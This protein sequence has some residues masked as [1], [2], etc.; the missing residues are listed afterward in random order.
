MC[1]TMYVVA[2]MCVQCAYPV[3][4]EMWIDVYLYMGNCVYTYIKIY[5]YICVC[6]YIYIHIY[7][8]IYIYKE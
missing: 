8:Y 4:D 6:V 1:C 3:A 5:T 2:G 7:I